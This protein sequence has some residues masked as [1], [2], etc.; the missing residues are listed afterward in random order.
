MAILAGWLL[1]MPLR[2]EGPVPAPVPQRRR[3]IRYVLA[4]FG[5]WLVTAGMATV[6]QA[7]F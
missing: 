3:L 4:F 5:T 2:P 1:I 6:V 7:R